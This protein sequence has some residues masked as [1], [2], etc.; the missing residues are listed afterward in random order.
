M[1]S[2]AAALLL[3]A[4]GCFV[5]LGVTAANCTVVYAVEEEEKAETEET[6]AAEAV[7]IEETEKKESTFEINSVSDFNHLA[8]NCRVNTWSD[9]VTVNLNTDLDFV[10][11]S[12]TNIAYFNGTFRGN[13]HKITH[14]E[15]T[16]P[17]FQAIGQYGT[18]QDLEL[19]SAV[20]STGDNTAAF[21]SRNSGTLERIRVEG[22]VSGKATTGMLAA[23]NEAGGLIASCEV[24]GTVTGDSST[25]GI[26]GKNFGTISSC[27]NRAHINTT[28]EDDSISAEDVKGVLENIL[29]TK[30][31]NSTENL[32]SRVDAGG[33]AGYNLSGALITDCVNEGVVGYPH[34]GYNTGGICG[35]N[36]GAVEKSV[37]K[38][39]VF[40]RKDIGGITGHQQPEI[41]VN[42]AEDV[43]A[44]MSK[45]LDDINGMITDT[46]NTSENLTKST[47]DRLSGLSKSM[48]EVKNSTNV[49]YD[50]SL[51]RF[52]E[53]ADSINSNTAV[54]LDTTENIAVETEGL[55]DSMNRLS[56]MSDNLNASIDSMAYA[57]GMSDA[58]KSSLRS[59]NAKLREDLNS[60]SAF[61]NE[62]QN[63]LLPEAPEER[64][65]RISDGLSRVNRL[66][67]DIRATRTILGRLRG[68]RDRIADGSL[69][70]EADRRDIALSSSV[71]SILDALDDL[72]TATSRLADFSSG[73][74]GSLYDASRGIDVNLQKN[75][76]VRAAGQDIY[77]GLDSISNQMDSLNAYAREESLEVIGN[78]NEINNRFN[79]MMDLLKNERDRLNNLADDGGVFVDYSDYTDSAARI[80]A[81]RNEADVRGDLTTGGVAGTIGIEYD[82]DP[83]KDVI[84]SNDRSLDYTF[85]VSAVISESENAGNVEGKGNY[86]GG[87]TGKMDLGHL[88]KNR[89]MGDVSSENGDFVGGVAGYAD[90]TLDGNS[91]RCRVGGGKNTGG[92]T[93]YGKTLR[94][95][96]AV[97]SDLT[98]GE[99]TGAI[100]GRVETLDEQLI[101]NN[102]YY[103]GSFGGI[104]NIDYAFMAER[105]SE[106]L[107]TVLV[108]F[109]VG[110]HLVGM[111]EVKAGTALKD[112]SFPETEKREGFLLLW[113][114]D[115]ETVLSEDAVVNGSYRLAVEVLHA[116]RSYGDTNRPV[117]M[118]DGAF[119]E[120]DKLDYST[121]GEDHYRIVIPED[122]LAERKIR[123]HK[124]SF[125][126]YHV[127]VNGAE[128]PVESFGDY[129]VF[130]SGERELE[131][132]IEKEGLPTEYIAAG[133]AAAAVLLILLLI[134]AFRKKKAK[135]TKE[136]SKEDK[137]KPE[138]NKEEKSQEKE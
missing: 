113:D 124:P 30:S 110:G 13:S 74:G 134:S 91:A 41:S 84:R 22:A 7:E 104:D 58:E 17:L 135:G 94:T 59:A 78:L 45:E 102:L 12:F 44:S 18:V 101:Q 42:F 62:V 26:A 93:G 21:V 125:K 5:A 117:L 95:N 6:E 132:L 92:V 38:G 31:F 8:R 56:S 76:A 69:Q 64:R 14:V 128:M 68:M 103:A 79:G 36:G 50:A 66:S 118:V 80:Y 46:L 133:A 136:E 87:I 75:D 54:I 138:E 70:V 100:A 81:C 61:V 129:L 40:G 108:K 39:A 35:R 126:R 57:F 123:V 33:I 23:V 1:K 96:T 49:I 86:A 60:T 72:D 29:I 122:G 43:L 48:T 24:S 67:Q 73:L 82:V 15:S 28:V 9:G 10:N 90:G 109:L 114:K 32:Q 130:N 16:K 111:E 19:H 105:A 120:E 71:S 55:T 137:E 63:G 11:E 52:D 20:S 37:N 88:Y 89:N 107:D 4:A 115:G 97:V 112:I 27:T 119:R 98:G 83:D 34:V 51:Q 131:I 25:G 85:G 77:A 116:P 127:L 99:Y 47:S 121:L 65:A 53:A 3:L 2:F 106:P